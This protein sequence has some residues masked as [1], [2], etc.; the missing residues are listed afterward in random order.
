MSTP[1]GA[2][3]P[4]QAQGRA[5]SPSA[6]L[7]PHSN[8][9]HGVITVI[10]KLVRATAHAFPVEADVLDALSVLHTFEKQYAQHVG[11][12]KVLRETDTAPVEDVRLRRA[13]NAS[14]VVPAGPAI[15]YAQLAAA[16]MAAGLGEAFAPKQPEQV[17]EITDVPAQPGPPQVPQF[18]QPQFTPPPPAPVFQPNPEPAEAEGVQP[19]VSQ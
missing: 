11:L 2:V 8:S 14:P 12:T 9:L 4:Y 6:V 15:D 18:Q 16:L 5:I 10:S 13:P 3:A 19:P 7:D 1:A 17:H